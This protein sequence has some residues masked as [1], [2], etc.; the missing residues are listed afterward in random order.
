MRWKFWCIPFGDESFHFIKLGRPEVLYPRAK[1][2]IPL[3]W[4]QEVENEQWVG[5]I[6]S[7]E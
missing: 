3:P 4:M 2:E 1:E 5:R 7:Q 6:V